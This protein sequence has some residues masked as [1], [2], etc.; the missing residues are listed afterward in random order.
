MN[1]FMK[2]ITSSAGIA[3]R[4]IINKYV[5]SL[6]YGPATHSKKPHGNQRTTF[7]IEWIYIKTSKVGEFLRINKYLNLFN[8]FI[9][10]DTTP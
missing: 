7:M 6:Y 3:G 1:Q 8:S 9:F 4:S 10:E 2:S 5:N